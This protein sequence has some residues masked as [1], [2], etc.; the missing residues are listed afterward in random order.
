MATAKRMKID[1][2]Q[3][4]T[5]IAGLLRDVRDNGMPLRDAIFGIDAVMGDEL[6]RGYVF[7][8]IDDVPKK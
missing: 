2:L 8:V 4:E 7:D 6:K 1:W 5:K 3:V